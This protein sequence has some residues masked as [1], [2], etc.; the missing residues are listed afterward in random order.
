[1]LRTTGK[2]I[3]DYNPSDEYHWI[4][5]HVLTR[6]D[7]EFFQT[8][9]LDNP[10]LEPSVIAE[11]ERLKEVDENYWRVY[12]L[13]ERAVG[14][15]TILTHYTIAETR[16]EGFKLLNYGLDFGF[17]NDPT[18]I[19]A[20][21]TDGRGF[22]LEELCYAT[23]MTNADISRFLRD[24]AEAGVA[25]IADSAEPK[26]IHEIHGHGLNVHPAR[27]GPD[28]IRAGLQFMQS[29]PL[30]VSAASENLIKEL[31]NYKWSEDKNGRLL[32]VPVAGNDHLIDAARYALMWN[33]SKPNF[34]KYVLG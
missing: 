32:N 29:R 6:D 4:Y 16:P 9:Y 10:Y 14:R 18:A 15:S 34:G 31:R 2:V 12:G 8:T 7:A 19:V 1:M 5:E 30:A 20:V 26:S 21:Y 17:T 25:V 11:I 24:T 3:I 27:K 23:G 33:Q 28:S 13:G 22:Y